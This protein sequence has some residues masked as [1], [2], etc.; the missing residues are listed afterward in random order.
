MYTVFSVFAATADAAAFKPFLC[1]PARP[2]RGY[3]PDGIELSYGDIVR[4]VCALRDQYRA[5][6]FGHGHRACLLLENRPDFIV[7][8]LALNRLDRSDQPG[9]SR[10]GNRIS[11]CAC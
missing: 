5:S 2:G 6:G 8:W 7:H 3:F 9:L 11:H 1:I 10:G 4:Q